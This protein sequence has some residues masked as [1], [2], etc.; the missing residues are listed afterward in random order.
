LLLPVAAHLSGGYTNAWVSEMDHSPRGTGT[1]IGSGVDVAPG[2]RE[3]AWLSNFSV[4]SPLG[5]SWS[6]I[7][8]I[9]LNTLG[10][11][12]ERSENQDMK[13][14]PSGSAVNI[15]KTIAGRAGATKP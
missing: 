3:V 5:P 11:G 14:K 2:S 7:P 8:L 10:L 9:S 1:L 15:P 12:Q 13:G 6:M 4:E